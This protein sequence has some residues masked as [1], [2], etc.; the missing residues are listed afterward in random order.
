MNA[1]E[2]IRS[3]RQRNNATFLSWLYAIA[4]NA[5]IDHVRQHGRMSALPEHFDMPERVPSATRIEA[6]ADL[7]RVREALSSLSETQRDIVLMRVWDDLPFKEIA[8]VLGK[9]EASCKMQ[10]SRALKTLR[11]SFATLAFLLISTL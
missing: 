1:L 9:S 4:R 11:L 2:K 3:Y 10:F 6:A 5:H 8:A 7:A